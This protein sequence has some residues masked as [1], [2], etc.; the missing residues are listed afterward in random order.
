M[1]YSVL[2]DELGTIVDDGTISR[3]EEQRYFLT[4]TTGNVDFVHQ[5]LEWW[6]A[7]AGW[8]VTIT[9][10]TAGLASMNLAG[11]LARGVLPEANRLRSFLS[12]PFPTWTGGRHPWPVFRPP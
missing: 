9:N 2:C 3:M 1:R 11:P 5:W 7:A 8:K 10:L 12:R 6:A 4:T